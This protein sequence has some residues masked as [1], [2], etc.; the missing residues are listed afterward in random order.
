M[1]SGSALIESLGLLENEGG[2]FEY[3]TRMQRIDHFADVKMAPE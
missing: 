3:G 1:Q 2:P